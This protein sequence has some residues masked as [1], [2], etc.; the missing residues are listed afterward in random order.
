MPSARSLLFKWRRLMT[1]GAKKPSAPR[2]TL[3]R[4]AEVRNL[5][6]QIRKLERLLGKKTLENEIL[7]E[8]LALAKSKNCSECAPAG[9]LVRRLQRRATPYRGL[10]MCFGSLSVSKSSRADA[11][12]P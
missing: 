7:R 2:T 9:R 10:R 6:R 11:D 12:G 1:E 4:R 3:S 5:K 8:A